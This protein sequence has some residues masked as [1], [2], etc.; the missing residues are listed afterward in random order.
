[1]YQKKITVFTPTYN[2]EYIIEELFKSLKRQT[3]KDFEWLIVDDG[4]T[5]GTEQKIREWMGKEEF[6][7]RYLKKENGGK[8]TAVNRGIETAQGELFFIVDSDDYLTEEA[9]ERVAYW[10]ETIRG[11]DGFAGVSGLRIHK[12]GSIIGGNG[13]MSAGMSYID[14]LNSERKRLGL[15]GDKAEVY[16]TDV[17]KR[18]YPI[19]VFQNENDVEIGV[20]WNRISHAGLKIRWFNEGIYVCEY[21]ADGLSHN[22]F[23]NHLKNFQGFICWKKELIDMQESFFGVIKEASEVFAITVAKGCSFREVAGMLDKKMSTVLLARLYFMLHEWK[24]K[25]TEG[26]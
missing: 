10:E 4:S 15:S 16:Y 25:L 2:R 18:H 19:P 26:K 6:P 21:L 14:V 9:L 23:S 7:V 12:D 8:H 17:L 22:S 5:D 20:L 1:M 3:Y 13:G 24:I 11:R